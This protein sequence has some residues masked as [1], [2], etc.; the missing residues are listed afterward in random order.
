[1]SYH[2]FNL[3]TFIGEHPD[4]VRVLTAWAT[5]TIYPSREG[6][7]D[8]YRCEARKV[9]IYSH[10]DWSGTLEHDYLAW[11]EHHFPKVAILHESWRSDAESDS[12]SDH[13]P[14]GCLIDEHGFEEN[15]EETDQETRIE[16][17][18]NE[19]AWKCAVNLDPDSE[20]VRRIRVLS[21][22]VPLAATF[23]HTDIDFTAF[24]FARARLAGWLDAVVF[25]GPVLPLMRHLQVSRGLP[26]FNLQELEDVAKRYQL[27]LPPTFE[28][29]ADEVKRKKSESTFYVE[30]AGQFGLSRYDLNLV[31]V[32]EVNH[33]LL[34]WLSGQP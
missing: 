27:I 10:H 4:L 2:A 1:M 3:T 20:L 6:T 29:I 34:N 22:Y 18:I 13:L 7:P 32:S 8:L 5:S 31:L 25:C 24:Q 26:A 15:Y 17:S 12:D 19:Y 16:H 30:V 28:E 11:F 21:R 9:T 33:G 14:E 23:E